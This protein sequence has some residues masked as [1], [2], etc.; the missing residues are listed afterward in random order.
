MLP[1]TALSAGVL[2]L[3]TQRLWLLS[4]LNGL[5]KPRRLA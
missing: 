5:T 1:L 3:E 4:N 2:D